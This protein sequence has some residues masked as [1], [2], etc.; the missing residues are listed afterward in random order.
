VNNL[1]ITQD[2]KYSDTLLL[3]KY[4]SLNIP[5]GEQP[6]WDY[7]FALGFYLSEGNLEYRK[8]KNT[9]RSLVNLNRYAKQKGMTLE[10][11]LEYMTDVQN[12]FLAVGQSDFERKYVDLVKKHFKFAKPH[13]V[14]E[15]GYQLY[16]SD[17]NYIHLIKDYTEGDDSHTKHLKNEVYNRSLKFLEGILDGFL[18]GDGNYKKNFDY[19]QIEITTN[20]RLYNNL[21]FLSKALGYDCHLEKGGV[22]KSYFVSN[23]NVYHYLQLFISKNWHR[24]IALGLV[25]EH[26]KSVEDVGVKETFNLVLRPLYPENDKRTEFNHLYFTA[27]GILVSDAVKSFTKPL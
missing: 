9:K 23:N 4:I 3:T 25:K 19:F 27:Y 21:I 17:L 13:K 26:I 5:K 7:G 2:P 20:C 14:S 18:C 16:S 12:V 24:H 11:Y 15:N 6:D 22:R 1:K 10:Q 8:H